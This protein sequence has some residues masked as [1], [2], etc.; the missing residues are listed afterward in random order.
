MAMGQSSALLDGRAGSGLRGGA[1]RAVA[2]QLSPRRTWRHLVPVSTV[3]TDVTEGGSGL[4]GSAP[5]AEEEA[6][7]AREQEVWGGTVPTNENSSVSAFMDEHVRIEKG[8]VQTV[9]IKLEA[10]NSLK[11]HYMLRN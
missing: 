3:L 4:Q 6:A 2:S 10:H 5:E 7:D 8:L 1:H 11:Y 9:S